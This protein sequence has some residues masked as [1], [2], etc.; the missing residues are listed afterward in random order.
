MG[1]YDTPSRRVRTTDTTFEIIE[2]LHELDT[3]TASELSETLDL[4]KS[5]VYDHLATLERKEYVV[6]DGEK[7]RLGVKFLSHGMQAKKSHEVA[8]VAK[9]ILNQLARESKE[10]VLL[11][12]EEHGRGVVLDRSI[13][14]R[15]VE[16]IGEVGNIYYLHHIAAGKAILANLPES[17][18]QT[19]LDR[20]GLPQQTGNTITDESS[21]LDDL[22]QIRKQGYA[23][24]DDESV[25]GLRAVA[26]PVL[27]DGM[28]VGAID[29]SGPRN[30]MHEDRLRDEL[31][32]MVK[33][34]SNE[35]ELRLT[36]F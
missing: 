33:G 30:R 18:I 13:G 35:I 10:A 36:E 27:K 12:V 24:E 8:H 2:T 31:A 26:A 32:N 19:L 6:K 4:A 1:M 17:E 14:D 22:E 11:V 16:T 29:L 21:L 5:T 7:F 15:A 23:I 9:P 34:A 3:A 20:H 28:P 25:Q